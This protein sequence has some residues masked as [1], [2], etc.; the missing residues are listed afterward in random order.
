MFV[1]ICCALFSMLLV[2]SCD[3]TATQESTGD[4]VESSPLDVRNCTTEGVSRESAL[5]AYDRSCQTEIREC[6]SVD[7]QWYCSSEPLDRL[8]WNSSSTHAQELVLLQSTLRDLIE[9]ESHDGS[10][11]AFLMPLSDELFDIPQDPLNPLSTAKV[12]LGKA[13]FHDTGFALNGISEDTRTWSCATCHSALTGFKPGIPQGIAEGG[14]GVGPDRFLQPGFDPMVE[15]ASTNKPDLQPI[16]VPSILNIAFQDVVLWNGQL[17]NTVNGR[18]NA[19]LP[20]GVVIP[21]ELPA[22]E[23]QWQL[24]GIETQAIAGQIIHRFRYTDNSPLQMKEA[25]RELWNAAYASETSSIVVNAGKAIAAFER[26]V[27]ANRAPFQRWLRGDMSAMHESELRGAIL[28]FGKAGCVS[29]H[30]GPALSSAVSATEAELFFAVGFADFDRNRIAIHGDIDET[31]RLGRGGFTQNS[32]QYYQFKIP[33]LYN[34]KDADVFGHGA[35]FASV[36]EVLRYK[37]SG[38]AQ[39]PKATNLDFRFVPLGLSTQEINELAAFIEDSL[40]DPD[41]SRYVPLSVPSGSCVSTC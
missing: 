23:N 28:F 1:K 6:L 4:V 2:G 39:N 21:A 20:Q 8:F 30:R 3:N 31:T 19:Q 38:K 16:A 32:E 22:S 9:V 10:L 5:L 36:R 17:G 25:Y 14:S 37:N 33:Q 29:C 12:A 18:V 11:R 24:S 34:L 41:L 7:G 26:T 13:F 27:L 40:Y 35:S 15:S